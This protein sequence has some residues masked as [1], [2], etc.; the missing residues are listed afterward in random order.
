MSVSDSDEGFKAVE[1]IGTQFSGTDIDF[2]S[3]VKK[4]PVAQTIL[5]EAA[6]GNYDLLMIG[7][8]ERRRRFQ[9][10]PWKCGR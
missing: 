1:R 4:G 7:A 5:Q 10:Y 9:V 3:V 2:T 6:I 8:T